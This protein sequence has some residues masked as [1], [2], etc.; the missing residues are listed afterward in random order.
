[1]PRYIVERTVGSLTQEELATVGKRS[2]EVLEDMEGVVWIKSYVSEA[3]GKIYCEYD[4]PSQ[5]A[6]MEHARRVGLPVD[7]ISEV[8]MEISPAMFR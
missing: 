3:A 4:A 2:N 7:R 6:I 8:K 5:E 1:M